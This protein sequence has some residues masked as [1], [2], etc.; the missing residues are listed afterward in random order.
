MKI[1]IPPF[2]TRIF[3]LQTKNIFFSIIFDVFLRLERATWQGKI[4][5]LP[6]VC[7]KTGFC[8][9]DSRKHGVSLSSIDVKLLQNK[10]FDD[11][12]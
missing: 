3:K 10:A 4:R 6:D 8:V 11:K 12:N 2:N 5:L 9:G 7:N 1:C